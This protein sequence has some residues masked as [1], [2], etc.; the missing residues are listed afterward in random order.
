MGTKTSC[1][2]TISTKSVCKQQCLDTTAHHWPVSPKQTRK[3]SGSHDHPG[4]LLQTRM[5]TRSSAA[6]PFTKLIHP[7][8]RA[9]SN[10]LPAPPPPGPPPPPPPP[11]REYLSMRIRN[12]RREETYGVAL[13]PATASSREK[14]RPRMADET[15]VQEPKPAKI[16]AKTISDGDDIFKT[17]E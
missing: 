2:D 5:R 9:L 12:N 1:L 13:V 8:H 10:H 4:M 7:R 11:A 17:Q 6:A 14:A 15:W 3:K 16:A